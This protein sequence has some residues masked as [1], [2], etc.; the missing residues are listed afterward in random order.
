[1][2]KYAISLSGGLDSAVLL[3]VLR[4]TIPGQE[5]FG[6]I[7]NY[8]S[9]H[10]DRENQ[11]ANAIAKHYEISSMTIDLKGMIDPF[12]NSTLISPAKDIPQGHYAAEP[13]RQTVVP[14]RNLI[15]ISILAGIAQSSGMNSIYIGVH[16]GDHYIYPDCRPDFLEQVRK[17]VTL[18][19]EGTVEL[20]APF[21]YMNKADIVARGVEINVPFHLTWTCYKGGCKACG[22]CGS[23]QERLEAFRLNGMEDPIEYETR[24]L[25]TA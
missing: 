24:E 2:L 9:K 10:N 13:M 15:F 12:N 25:I 23:C 11:A 5:I 18:S 3:G 1:M 20:K 6:V 16:A 21:V 7:Y 8:G 17:T 22:V 4:H 19:S 14:G